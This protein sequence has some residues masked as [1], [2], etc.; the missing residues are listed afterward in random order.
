LLRRLAAERGTSPIGLPSGRSGGHEAHS[1]GVRAADAFRASSSFTLPPRGGPAAGVASSSRTSVNVSPNHSVVQQLQQAA[2]SAEHDQ[3]DVSSQRREFGGEFG[4][5]R[6]YRFGV[7]TSDVSDADD[8][9]G[10]ALPSRSS[11]LASPLL[12]QHQQHQQQHQQ[13]PDLGTHDDVNP[14]GTD[15]EADESGEDEEEGEEGEDINHDDGDDDGGDEEGDDDAADGGGEE[16]ADASQ[17]GEAALAGEAHH[18]A[19]GR[20]PDGEAPREEV[21]VPNLD[22]GAGADGDGVVDSLSAPPLQPQP[23]QRGRQLWVPSLEE[24]LLIAAQQGL[25]TQQPAPAAPPALPAS[26]QQLRGI[27]SAAERAARL[28]SFWA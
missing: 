16:D 10:L 7:D 20:K 27:G 17:L 25:T 24:L 21:R 12:Q 3:A 5:R 23:L 14:Y 15:E 28:P 9:H 2:A 22:G 18:Q 19:F 8:E 26:S 11:R 13:Q 1:G 6:R 4:R